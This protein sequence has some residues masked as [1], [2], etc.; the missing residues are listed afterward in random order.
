MTLTREQQASLTLLLSEARRHGIAPPTN[1]AKIALI[2]SRY[3]LVAVNAL[4][5]RQRQDAANTCRRMQVGGVEAWLAECIAPG[6]GAEAVV[7]S[8]RRRKAQAQRT[9]NQLSAFM[10]IAPVEG[11]GI[12]RSMQQAKPATTAGRP[13]VTAGSKART[14]RRASEEPSVAWLPDEEPTNAGPRRLATGDGPRTR[15]RLGIARSGF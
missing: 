9:K 1:P 5:P 12:D 13:P 7:A 11:S 10:G 14:T 8:N 4:S 2:S 15:P 6:K 3:D